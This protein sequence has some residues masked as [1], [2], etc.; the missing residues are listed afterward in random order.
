MDLKQNRITIRSHNVNGFKR[1]KDFIFSQCEK[2]PNMI[3][4]LQEH[5]LRPPYKKQFGVNQLRC[6]HPNFD[7]FGTSAMAKSSETNIISG[8][9]FGGTG[10]VYSKKYARCIKPVLSLVHE[11][12]TALEISTLNDKVIL[13]NCYFPYFNS[14][15]IENHQKCIERQ[16]AL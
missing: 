8:R 14:R 2:N 10:F 6:V 9:P 7:G 1:S 4:A 15:D 5:W 3:I 16:L 13:I 11:R 12:V